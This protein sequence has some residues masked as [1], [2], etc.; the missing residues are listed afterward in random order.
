MEPALDQGMGTRAVGVAVQVQGTNR[1]RALQ[2][3]AA[4]VAQV[5]RE[6]KGG[7]EGE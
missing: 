5:G 6:K 7:N 4:A 2:G 3:L 1:V